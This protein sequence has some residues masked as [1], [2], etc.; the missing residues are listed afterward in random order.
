MA[1]FWHSRELGVDERDLKSLADNTKT[2][3]E[4]IQKIENYLGH[5]VS[6]LADTIISNTTIDSADEESIIKLQSGQNSKSFNDFAE[7]STI[8]TGY[9]IP[10]QCGHNG[11][12]SSNELTLLEIHLV[13]AGI[14]AEI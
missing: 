7:P 11:T 9:L 10:L 1:N 8:K 6:R 12:W 4:L 14:I 5:K 3:A 13:N 2:F